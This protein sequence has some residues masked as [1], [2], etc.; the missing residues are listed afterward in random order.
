M[1]QLTSRGWWFQLDMHGGAQ[2]AISAVSAEAT[3]YAHRDKLY[4]IQFYDRIPEGEFPAD[5]TR[6][7]NGWVDAVTAPLK[8]GDWGMYINYADPTLDR[9]AAQRLYY[10]G[11][12]RR[13]QRLK[14]KFDPE[15]RF[16]YPQSIRPVA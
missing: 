3:S 1:T 9:E 14:A 5:G 15:E 16:Y 2:S 4:I 6:F 12:L 7:L 8:D 11:N 13:L 10:G